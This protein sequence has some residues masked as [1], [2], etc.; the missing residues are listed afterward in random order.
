MLETVRGNF[1]NK[2]KLTSLSCQS[3]KGIVDQ[4]NATNEEPIDS[5]SHLLT[6]CLAFSDLRNQFNTD[7]DLGLVKFFTAVIERRKEEEDMISSELN[8]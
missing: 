6:S 7:S 2:Y 5:Q 4:N 3:C 1:S 8:P